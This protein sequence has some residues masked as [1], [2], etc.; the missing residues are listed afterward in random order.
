MLL[1]A[2]PVLEDSVASL[3]RGDRTPGLAG[4]FNANLV[5]TGDI[6]PTVEGKSEMLELLSQLSIF[7]NTSEPENSVSRKSVLFESIE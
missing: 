6:P 7:V 4:S 1:I 3:I 2:L 5:L